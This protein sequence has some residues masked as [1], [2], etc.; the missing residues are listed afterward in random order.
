MEL[1]FDCPNYSKLKKVKLASIEFSNYAIIW[2]DQLVLNRRRNREY[3][4]DALEEM[5]AVMRK[6]CT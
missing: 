4:I 1:V 5:K 3:L 2:W 6:I